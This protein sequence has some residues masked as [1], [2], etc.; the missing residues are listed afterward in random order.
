[1]VKFPEATKRMFGSVFVCKKCKVKRRADPARVLAK[2]VPCRKCGKKDL[3]TISK[4][5]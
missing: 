4:G 3:R 5:K 2:K 1:M